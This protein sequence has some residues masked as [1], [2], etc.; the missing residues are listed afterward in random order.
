VRLNVLKNCE[1]RTSTAWPGSVIP[2]IWTTSVH[3]VVEGWLDG[4][5]SIVNSRKL[6]FT[7]VISADNFSV[8]FSTILVVSFVVGLV[9][10]F[11]VVNGFLVVVTTV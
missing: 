5:F 6:V 4:W 11:V 9:I 7:T 2:S 3:S 1:I 10:C 8:T